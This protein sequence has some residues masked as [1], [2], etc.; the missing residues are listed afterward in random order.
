ML[1]AIITEVKNIE[2]KN[3]QLGEYLDSKISNLKPLSE[4]DDM[5]EKLSEGTAEVKCIK[6]LNSLLDGKE[7]PMTGVPFEKKEIVL[8][9]KNLVEGVFPVFESTYEVHLTP[10][11]MEA[12]DSRQFKEC[13]NS[14]KEKVI[15]TPEWAKERFDEEQVEQILAG[16]SPDGFTWHHNEEPG[17]MEL[18]DREIHDKTAHTGGK[19]VWG[20]G[21]E[22]R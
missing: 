16:E 22:N 1:E 12:S 7:H 8:T 4:L 5:R 13:N 17:K 2:K 20:G 19:V 6:T 18:V 15:N 11:N 21:S 10:E 9:D 3:P 14:L